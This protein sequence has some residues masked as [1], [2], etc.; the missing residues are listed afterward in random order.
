[1][2]TRSSPFDVQT[3]N[4][5]RTAL[6]ARERKVRPTILPSNFSAEWILLQKVNFFILSHPARQHSGAGM[7]QGIRKRTMSFPSLRRLQVLP[8]ESACP[9]SQTE[10]SE[11]TF[12]L[13]SQLCWQRVKSADIKSALLTKTSLTDGE[14]ALLTQESD[15]LTNEAVKTINS[16]CPATDKWIGWTDEQ[17]RFC[18]GEFR[19][20]RS[21]KERIWTRWLHDPAGHEIFFLVRTPYYAI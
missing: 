18:G 5:P 9:S 20:W 8:A 10:I 15:R 4:Y 12:S 3:S 17:L 21:V 2:V 7:R 6:W 1:M 19:L 14:S 16:R 11:Q 13:R